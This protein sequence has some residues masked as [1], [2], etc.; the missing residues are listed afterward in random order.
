MPPFP[1]YPE[2]T[3]VVARTD[4]EAFAAA[5]DADPEH[6]VPP[7]FAAVYALATSMPQMLADPEVGIDV[8]RMLH[9]EQQFTW[10]NHPEIGEELQACGQ[11]IRD[12]TKGTLRRVT[13][14]TRVTGRAGR[15]IC[16]AHST[17]VVR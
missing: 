9:G 16:T 14:E 13:L 10:H 7:T 15:Q 5:V 12:E 8:G 17:M 4:V 6:G 11:I 1:A 3:T 2:V